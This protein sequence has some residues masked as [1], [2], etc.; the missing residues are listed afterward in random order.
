MG[1]KDFNLQGAKNRPGLNWQ[2]RAGN[3]ELVDGWRGRSTENF[4]IVDCDTAELAERYRKKFKDRITTIVETPRGGAHFYHSGI[5]R[6]QQNVKWDVRGQG[7]YACCPPSP[8]YR[9]ET[10]LVPLEYLISF[11]PEIL[12]EENVARECTTIV[13][14]A[15]RYILGIFAKSGQ[16]G[17]N[18][19]FKA[20]CKLR[21]EGLSEVEALAEMISWNETNSDPKWTVKELL[22]K[23]RDVYSKE[24]IK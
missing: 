18:A 22:H 15:R 5:T 4:T 17:H 11:P 10:P 20:C 16:R 7:G 9:Y 12:K 23:V 21:K 13:R 19:T 6:N 1:Y 14:E 24:V 3:E 8:G 2:Q